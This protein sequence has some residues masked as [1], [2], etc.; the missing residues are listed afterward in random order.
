MTV[1]TRNVEKI[2]VIDLITIENKTGM[3]C[4]DNIIIFIVYV[5]LRMNIL[6][7]KPHTTKKVLYYKTVDK[8]HF[9]YETVYSS[10]VIITLARVRL[11]NIPI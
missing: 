8:S 10:T 4:L 7:K 9:L 6:A 5:Y 1:T 11:R 3:K 2:Y